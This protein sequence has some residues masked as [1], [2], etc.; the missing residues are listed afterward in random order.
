MQDLHAPASGD[1]LQALFRAFHLP[2]CSNTPT[3]LRRQTTVDCRLS[4]LL[5]RA[6]FALEHLYA[7]LPKRPRSSPLH[8][9]DDSLL[10]SLLYRTLHS[11]QRLHYASCFLV[12]PR[13]PRTLV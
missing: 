7:A 8:S 11:W 12:E 4:P 1:A 5:C 3:P 10:L 2:A 9:L 6:L 13:A